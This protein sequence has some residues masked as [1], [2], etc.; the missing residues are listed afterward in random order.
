MLTISEVEHVARLASLSLTEEEKKLFCQQLGEILD[1]AR[2]LNKIDTDGVE[3]TF[4]SI[5]LTNI[6]RED[7]AHMSMD[8][9]LALSNAPQREEH[10][11][12]IPKIIGEE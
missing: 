3:P 11:F 12:K 5:R 7:E 10:Y 6:F 1:F 8:R 2:E 4:H 9:E